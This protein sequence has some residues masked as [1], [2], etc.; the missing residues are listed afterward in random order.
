[1]A[2]VAGHRLFLK[3]RVKKGLVCLAEVEVIIADDHSLIREG[4]RIFQKLGAG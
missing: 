4:L 3:G 1:M 2:A